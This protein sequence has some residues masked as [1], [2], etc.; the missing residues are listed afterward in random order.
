MELTEGE[1][2]LVL[3][4]EQWLHARV[5]HYSPKLGNIRVQFVSDSSVIS[6]P[7]KEIEATVRRHTSNRVAIKA[8][9]L[10]FLMIIL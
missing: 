10:F 8:L 7:R 9:I 1:S 6:I 5:V 2:V 3:S 4:D